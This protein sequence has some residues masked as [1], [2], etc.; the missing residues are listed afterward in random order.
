MHTDTNNKFFSLVYDILLGISFQRPDTN[1]SIVMMK[2][3]VVGDKECGKTCLQLFYATGNFPGEYISTVFD[4]YSTRIRVDNNYIEISL[5]DTAGLLIVLDMHVC[6][7]YGRLDL[8][9]FQK[10]EFLLA[11]CY[12]CWGSWLLKPYTRSALIARG[13]WKL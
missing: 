11:S 9:K 12:M 5:W 6:K 3:M 8:L 13:P 7:K 2:L 10:V 1:M 4:N